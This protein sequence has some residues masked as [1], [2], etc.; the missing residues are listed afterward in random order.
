MNNRVF[1]V[2]TLWELAIPITE[3]KSCTIDERI[4]FAY[5]EGDIMPIRR[6]VKTAGSID[7]ANRQRRELIPTAETID[8]FRQIIQRYKRD[9]S[10][11]DRIAMLDINLLMEVFLDEEV[12]IIRTRQHPS[13]YKVSCF[14]QECR[15]NTS[16]NANVKWAYESQLIRKTASFY[17]VF[18]PLCKEWFG[19]SSYLS[20]VFT[21]E[22]GLWLANMVTHYRHIHVKSWD[23]MWGRYGD[24]YQRAAN[25]HDE[26]YED[27]KSEINERAKRQIARKAPAFLRDNNIDIEVFKGLR[28]TSE[29]TIKV[30]NSKLTM[31][32]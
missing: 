25:Y 20:T 1:K 21:E 13:V 32:K 26:D 14:N 3:L 29:K 28:G 4:L 7:E 22:R 2:Y 19:G 10:D 9:D 17:Q 23:K 11:Y 5:W 27:R 15:T 16:S 18:C 31:N 8:G 6:E 24:F 12:L 30:V